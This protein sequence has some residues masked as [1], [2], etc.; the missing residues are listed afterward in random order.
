[1]MKPERVR[2]RGA[3]LDM[4]MAC[5]PH[6]QH[7]LKLNGTTIDATNKS[8]S[9]GY[10]QVVYAGSCVPA[11]IAVAQSHFVNSALLGDSHAKQLGTA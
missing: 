8:I 5:L 11:V 2:E 3:S 6:E 7:Y 10:Y 1:M 4:A 9:I